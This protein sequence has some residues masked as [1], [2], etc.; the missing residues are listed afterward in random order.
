MAAGSYLIAT[1]SGAAT[2]TA[3]SRGASLVSPAVLYQR[4]ISLMALESIDPAM[5]GVDAASARVSLH[6]ALDPWA[7]AAVRAG[8]AD[9]ASRRLRPRATWWDSSPRPRRRGGW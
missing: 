9:Q 7:L 6:Y 8:G 1:A 4:V 5:A 3:S 2:V